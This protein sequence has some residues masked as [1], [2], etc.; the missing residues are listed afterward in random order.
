MIKEEAVKA[1]LE[2]AQRQLEKD[3]KAP[4]KKANLEKK[5]DVHNKLLER[6]ALR[7]QAGSKPENVRISPVEPEAVVQKNETGSRLCGIL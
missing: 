4:V 6:Q 1:A 2:E 5:T 7:K 3:P